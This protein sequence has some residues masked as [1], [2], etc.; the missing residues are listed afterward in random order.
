MATSTST[1]AAP[2]SNKSLLIVLVLVAGAL[3]AAAGVAGYFLLA[4]AA[5]AGT[6]GAP[7]TPAP[8]FVPLDPWTVNLQGD[9]RTRFLHV[10]LTLKAA[11]KA[12]QDR[13]AEYLPEVRSRVLT[14]LSNRDPATLASAEDKTR[15]AGEIMAA[16]NRPFAPGLPEQHVTHVM[17]T[18]FVL[19]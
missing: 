8:I 2:R 9:G 16:V 6:P 7:V 14:L 11:D 3:L 17:F 4:R 1:A 19:Q 15:L 18:A 10:G 13:I 12:T 5:A